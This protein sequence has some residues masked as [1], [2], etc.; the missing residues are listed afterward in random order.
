MAISALTSRPSTTYAATIGASLLA[1]LTMACAV[2]ARVAVAPELRVEPGGEPWSAATHYSTGTVR[3]FAD[4]HPACGGSNRL[5]V[6]SGPTALG[7]LYDAQATRRPLRP[8]R[9]TDRFSS[10]DFICGIG[11]LLTGNV[12]Y[13]DVKVNMLTPPVGASEIRLRSRDR[14]LWFYVDTQ[15]GQNTGAALELRAP[16][17]ARSG[18]SVRVRVLAHDGT[19]G[20]EPAAG[21]RVHGVVAD[22][23]GE[24]K[25]AAPLQRRLVLRATRGNDVASVPVSVCLSDSGRRCPRRRGWSIVGRSSAERLRGTSGPDE[26]RARGGD[27]VLLIR[28]GERDIVRCGPGRDTVFASDNDRVA[29]D[30]ERVRR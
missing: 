15:T 12:R 7:V 27:D 29:R 28:G 9:T 30:C 5:R 22:A 23:R 17:R 26:I 10:G 13:W 11:P 20:V 24:A 21:A 3:F 6:V 1:F 16:A 25:V 14:V 8:V 19:G 18:H 2:Q 4:A